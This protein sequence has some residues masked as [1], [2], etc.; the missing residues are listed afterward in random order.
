[1]EEFLRIIGFD[2]QLIH[3]AV[4]MGINIFILF[5]F[6]SYFLFNPVQDFL[7]KRRQRIAGQ[8]AEA[9]D[10]Q[11]AAKALKEEYENRLKEI[12][13]EADGIL[14][15]ARRKAK[16]KEAD[17]LAEARN[18]AARIVERANRQAEL[19]RQKA[20]DEMKRE[21]IS[22][23]SLMAGKLV[24]ASIDPAMQDRLFD[25]TLKEIGENTWL[26]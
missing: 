7:E 6:L 9:A 13:T 20:R 3:D 11:K 16:I 14:A 26:Q 10:N 15:E 12:Q 24:T 21:M 5:F 22:V 17:I 8:L 23:A 18:E 25:E 2:W 4:L 1:M 19:E